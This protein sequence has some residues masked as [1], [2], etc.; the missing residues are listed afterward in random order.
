MKHLC[1][2]FCLL[3]PAG[4]VNADFVQLAGSL[5]AANQDGSDPNFFTDPNGIVPTMATGEIFGTLDT[6]NFT[7]DFDLVVN[8]ISRDDLRN[9]GPNMTPIH[10]HLPEQ[11]GAFGP[12]AVDLT[13][14]AMDSDFTDTMNGFE[15]SRTVSILLEDQGG[16]VIGMHPGNDLIVDGLQSGNAFALVHTTNPNITGFPFGEIRGNIGVVPEPSSALILG[17]G[18]LSL[19]RRRK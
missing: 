4:A 10:L 7:F 16:V 8:G 11:L 1:L 13:L 14:G 3:I 2:L 17:L 12:I 18:T 19:L 15:L 9:F 5:S 6:D